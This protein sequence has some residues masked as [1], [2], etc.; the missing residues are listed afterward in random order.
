MK[1][2]PAFASFCQ[3][4]ATIQRLVIQYPVLKFYTFTSRT[5]TNRTKICNHRER[6]SG[7]SFCLWKIQSI[8]STFFSKAS[9]VSDQIKQCSIW[10]EFQAKNQKLQMQSHELPD[11]PWS[12]VAADQFRL[13]GKEYIVLVDFYLD[14]MEVQNWRKTLSVLKLNS[15]RNNSADMAFQ[16]TLFSLRAMNSISFQLIGSLLTYLLPCIITDPTER[17]SLLW[18]LSSLCSENLSKTTK[19]CG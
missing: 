5:L 10:N 15:L 3:A 9:E 7:N 1:L 6:M 16:T 14:F 12:R 13:R 17:Q 2:L 18:K 19:T 8:S 4:F 11:R